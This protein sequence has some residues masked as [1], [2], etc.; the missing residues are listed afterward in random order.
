MKLLSTRVIISTAI[1][2]GAF[3][4]K[5]VSADWEF[6]GDY[7]LRFEHIS[8]SP[9]AASGASDRILGSRLMLKTRYTDENFYFVGELQDARAFLDDDGSPLGTDD[10][11][12]LEPIQAHLGWKWGADG[13]NDFKVGRF[14]LDIGKRRLIAR[15]KFRNTRNSFTGIYTDYY[16]DDYRIQG[17][18]AMPDNRFP[19][20]REG[21]DNNE[22]EF[23][24][25]YLDNIIAG[26]NVT[27]TLASKDI[28]EGYYF[29]LT[30]DDQN[31]L[32]T[33]NRE[34]STIGFRWYRKPARSQIDF[35]WEATYQFGTARA[36][37]SNSDIT[38]LDVSAY[39]THF[40]V[41]YTLSD[42]WKSRILF[43]FEYATGD[44]DSSDDEYNRYDSL[45]G[46]RRSDFNA[47]NLYGIFA[48][49][50]VV[51]P[52]VRWH[53]K[54]F[55]KTSAFI[56]YRPYWLES[57]DDALPSLRRVSSE[58]DS[59]IGHQVEARYRWQYSKAL[60]FELGAIYLDKGS[61]F[62]STEG[63]NGEG[64]TEYVYSEVRFF[65]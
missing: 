57:A 46:V 13:K 23:D 9:R 49:S 63:V 65:F 38:D 17:L 52:G 28:V 22:F 42:S 51:S 21:L 32:N 61:Y 15:P 41:G 47:T 29:G 59:F 14:T 8:E 55:E 62:E 30:E 25:I 3:Y 26:I 44:K 4:A 27:H 2:S 39:F 7:A 12:A 36:S 37:S 40:T 43:E 24:K 18:V 6:S 34:I 10:V 64:N 31:S 35:E 58:G 56:A 60:R 48:R 11:N 5:I 53:F 45:F 1:L 33:R 50:N 16:A 54:P 19:R 20:D